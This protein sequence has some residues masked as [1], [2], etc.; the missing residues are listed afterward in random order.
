MAPAW[1]EI[2]DCALTYSNDGAKA[3]SEDADAHPQLVAC[4]AH[5]TSL[6]AQD[7]M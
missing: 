5:Q 6:Q 2:K 7:W 4:S 1:N 3:E